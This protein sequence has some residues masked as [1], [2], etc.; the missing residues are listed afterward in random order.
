[1]T[2]RAASIT[3]QLRPPGDT[4]WIT[5]TNDATLIDERAL[6]VDNV[7]IGWGRPTFRD[8]PDP[9]TVT[10]DLIIPDGAAD[11]ALVRYDTEVRLDAALELLQPDG[12]WA[13]A[14]P[15]PTPLT[16]AWITSWERTRAKDSRRYR[17]TITAL[18]E[19][20]RAAAVNLAAAPWPQEPAQGRLD[21]INQASPVGTLTNFVS[22]AGTVIPRDVDN[23]PALDVIRETA[24][25]SADAVETSDGRIWLKERPSQRIQTIITGNLTSMG[26]RV[27]SVLEVPT[28]IVV[29]SGQYLDRSSLLNEATIEHGTAGERVTTSYREPGSSYSSSRW[30]RTTDV[31]ATTGVVA[32]W[33]ADLIAAQ[34]EPAVQL[35]DTQ[36]VLDKPWPIPKA[37][38]LVS[39]DHRHFVLAK[40]NG[41]NRH[42]DVDAIQAVRGGV[43]TIRGLELTLVVSLEPARVY[44][45]RRLR[46]ATFPRSPHD[47]ARLRFSN[48]GVGPGRIRFTDLSL[49]TTVHPS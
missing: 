19:L 8:H 10:F 35:N 39:M 42:A 37:H 41:S 20:G 45:I 12:S 31:V 29:D 3:L 18:D 1:M 4:S 44:G 15:S 26:S 14:S 11:T 2:M 38:H 28:A 34:G 27:E 22:G 21:K 48:L 43:L 40:L 32:A 46:W 16:R 36:L 17:Y 5:V 49:I 47:N 13:A 33:L 30:T 6:A 9:G 23:A 7:T 25:L 24:R